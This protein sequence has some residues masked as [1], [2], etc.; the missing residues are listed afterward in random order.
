MDILGLADALPAP[1]ASVVLAKQDV[2]SR[3]LVRDLLGS[4]HPMSF[5]SISVIAKARRLWAAK[6]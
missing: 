6:L 3:G 5:N 2:Q 4:T 1:S